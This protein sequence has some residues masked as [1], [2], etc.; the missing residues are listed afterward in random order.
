MVRLGVNHPAVEQINMHAYVLEFDDGDLGLWYRVH[1][2]HIPATLLDK[3]VNEVICELVAAQEGLEAGD[4][5]VKVGGLVVCL[6]EVGAEG[7][8]AKQRVA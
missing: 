3:V 8:D 6:K 1:I 5:Q 7:L 4:H 2:S